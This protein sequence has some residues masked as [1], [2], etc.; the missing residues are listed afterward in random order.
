MTSTNYDVLVISNCLRS[1]LN[2]TF[3]EVKQRRIPCAGLMRKQSQGRE[4]TL[5]PGQKTM[6]A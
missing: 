2:G 1:R 4:L 6:L 3:T 5:G